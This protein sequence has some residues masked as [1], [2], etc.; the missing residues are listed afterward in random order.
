MIFITIPHDEVAEQPGWFRKIINAI[1]RDLKNLWNI[2]KSLF[3][4]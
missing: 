2:I 1:W 3:G 4:F